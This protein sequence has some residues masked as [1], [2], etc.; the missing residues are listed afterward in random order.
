ME[1]T[2]EIPVEIRGE[3]RVFLAKVQAWRYGHRFL[4]DVDGVAVT[5]ERDD[6]GEFRAILPDG[7][8][9]KAPDKKVVSASSRYCK[10]F[11][12]DAKCPQS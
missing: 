12:D 5:I 2:I 6:A 11:E 3:E 8:S 4:V 9:G 7:F 1:Q 10:H